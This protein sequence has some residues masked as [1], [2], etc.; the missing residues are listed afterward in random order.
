MKSDWLWGMFAGFAALFATLV[1]MIR[2]AAPE[3]IVSTLSILIAL[4]AGITVL[5]IKNSHSIRKERRLGGEAQLILR[6]YQALA[7]TLKL[8]PIL[9]ILLIVFRYFVSEVDLWRDIP[10]AM[11]IAIVQGLSSTAYRP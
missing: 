11:M 4:T 5:L 1:L 6:P 9:C 8:F 2:T 7:M 3:P 10:F